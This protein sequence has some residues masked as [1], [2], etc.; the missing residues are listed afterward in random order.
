MALWG[1]L[2]I[3]FAGE[4][5]DLPTHSEEGISAIPTRNKNQPSHSYCQSLP[6]TVLPPH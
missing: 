4:G 6:S 2:P 3:F 1:F 5:R